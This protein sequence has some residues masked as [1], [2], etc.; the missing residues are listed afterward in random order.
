[1]ISITITGTD[2]VKKALSNWNNINRIVF[3]WM[4]SGQP[5][6]IMQ[7]SFLENF[8]FQGRPKWLPLAES[9]ILQR[10]YQ[11]YDESPI[12][13]RSGS[14][15][16]K[17]TSM[18]GKAET[19]LNYSSITWGIEQL[20]AETKKKFGPNQIGKGRGG[21][22]LPARPMIGFQKS[23]GKKLVTSLVEWIG[24]NIV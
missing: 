11:G 13:Q 2:R 16:D 20:D 8:R 1:M 22:N 7:K 5:D 17:V 24:K 6:E 12:L 23:D 14:L 9:T 19:A 21:Q 4:K 15:M 18:R 3:N 10:E